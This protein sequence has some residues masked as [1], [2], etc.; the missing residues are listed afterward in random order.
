M[1]PKIKENKPVRYRTD[2]YKQLKEKRRDAK[3][4]EYRDIKRP[5]SPSSSESE[6]DNL[7]EKYEDPSSKVF[8]D[9]KQ[10]IRMQLDEVTEA[11]EYYKIT[12][13]RTSDKQ[14]TDYFRI[15]KDI[16][17]W[18]HPDVEYQYI[19]ENLSIKQVKND[20]TNDYNIEVTGLR[21]RNNE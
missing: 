18:P 4:G 20:V 21:I 9:E 7:A 5:G 6:D 12:V 8:W 3:Y 17:K 14:D 15:E 13:T 1:I 16:V 2:E 11:R 10:L 19:T